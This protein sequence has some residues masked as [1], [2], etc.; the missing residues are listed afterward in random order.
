MKNKGFT[1][2]ELIVVIAVLAVLALILVPTFTGL[3]ADGQRAVCM[4][5]QGQIKRRYQTEAMLTDD[6][7]SQD[8]LANKG[9]A[10]FGQTPTCPAGGEYVTIDYVDLDGAKKAYVLCSEHAV[11]NDHYYVESVLS[12]R[13]ANELM[14]EYKATSDKQAFKEKYKQEY[15]DL[16]GID[17][18]KHNELLNN[19][20]MRLATSVTLSKD[21]KWEAI[22]TAK[23]VKHNTVALYVQP[24]YPPGTSQVILFAGNSSDPKATNWNAGMVYNHEDGAWYEYIGGNNYMMTNLDKQNN[25]NA[26]TWEQLKTQMT[27]DTENWKKLPE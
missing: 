25:K 9:G 19:E 24:Y 17:L 5:T 22:D 23:A 13:K 27:T 11:G 3:I 12:K 8:V 10:Y 26:I 18:D 2:V 16:F 4:D 7:T 6:I 1:L 15:L 20:A 14:A 21:G